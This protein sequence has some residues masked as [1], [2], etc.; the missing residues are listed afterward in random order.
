MLRALL[1]Q[2]FPRRR[3]ASADVLA[4]GVRAL[5]EG[6]LAE[7]EERFR[8][9]IAH[10]PEH[11]D[12]RHLLGHVLLR[13]KRFDES[14][15]ALRR[16]L[17]TAP[18]TAQ[19]WFMLGEAARG[20]GRI[21]EACD[22]FG[23]A[24]ALD[25]ASVPA[26]IAR[27]VAFLELERLD[28]AEADCRAVIELEPGFAPAHHNLGNVLHR[29]GRID[30][31]IAAYA[32]A[33]ELDPDF[34]S[35]HSNLVY[36]LNFSPAWTPS[37]IYEAHREWSRRH[38]AP[39]RGQIRPHANE[40]V[41]GRRLRIGYVSPNFREHPVAAFFE[42]ALKHHDRERFSIVL[43]SD[44]SDPDART[45]RLRSYGD[46]WRDIARLSDEAVAARVRADD[47]DILVD[48]TGHTDGHRL[49][50]FA[51]KPAP[52]QVTWNGY[53]NTTGLDTMDYRITDR[54]ADPPGAADGWH[55][56]RLMRL[57]EIY[58][59]FDPP[60]DAPQVSASPVLSRGYVTFG[61]FNALA[62]I[63]PQVIAAWARLLH[64]VP[65]ARLT[66][67]T[68][69]EGEARARVTRAFAEHG[70]PASR[71]ALA[72]RLAFGA[73]LAAVAE[74]DIA[75]D[76][77]PFAGTTTTCQTLWMGVP[78]VTLAGRSHAGRVGV[79]MLTNVGL[80]DLVARDEDDYVAIAAALACRPARLAELRAGMRARMLASPLTDGAR[81]ARAVED[82]YRTMWEA[83]CRAP[84]ERNT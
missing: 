51:R 39:L 62:K 63:T 28:D 53:A 24:I 16:L 38:A 83:Y 46:E 84:G 57:P 25:P 45:A 47:I 20:Q 14:E 79:S 56:E 70:I 76:P 37:R 74:A 33:V 36:A 55:S 52:V 81:L 9:A 15:A 69:A 13:Q 49:L 22:A 7:A 32:R 78:V 59:A 75:L 80:A 17:D 11:A 71:L 26:L 41:I 50:V 42:P 44:V 61:S 43:Y 65:N 23:R 64:A 40:R 2:L 12:A 58:M 34:V 68:V 4:Q 1:T 77:F 73:F 66:M 31:A 10:H 5:R 27:A 82:A 67:L 30:E 6:R 18:H 48:L 60:R 8:A 29:A 19:A 35:A 21:A 3:P 54:H 72:G